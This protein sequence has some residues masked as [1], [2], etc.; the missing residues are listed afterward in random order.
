MTIS[1]VHLDNSG[2]TAPTFPAVV[3]AA[4]VHFDPGGR[5]R[6]SCVESVSV[7]H[8]RT[9]RGRVVAGTEHTVLV[10]GALLVLP[11]GLDQRFEA[12]ASSPLEISAVHLVPAHSAAHPVVTG[13]ATNADHPLAGHPARHDDA[14]PP[15]RNGFVGSA[16]D[17]PHLVGMVR[18]A[19][20]LFDDG[21]PPADLLRALGALLRHEL[22]SLDNPRR[23]LGEV[24]LPPDVEAVVGHVDANLHETLTVRALAD[25]G[26]Y[27]EATLTRRFRDVLGVSPM[28]WVIERRLRRATDLLRTTTLSVA[29]IGSRCG[30]PDPY[31]FSRAF[32]ARHGESPTQWR[33]TQG[34]T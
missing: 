4:D 10:R 8:C 28:A 29:Q 13:L 20:R 1:S 32:R 12:D 22:G 16:S 18:Y 25:V 7:I 17:Y 34:V 3:L 11:W 23:A 30:Y 5:F 15:I 2:M 33:R 9:G 24:E 19:V 31:Y 14:A 26:G 6:Y 27:T 21:P